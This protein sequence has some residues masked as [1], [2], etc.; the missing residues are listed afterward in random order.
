MDRRASDL[1]QLLESVIQ[2]IGLIHDELSRPA[3]DSKTG[4]AIPKAPLE[5][6]RRLKNTVDQFRL[7]LWAYVDSHEGEAGDPAA[8]LRHLRIERAAD[9]LGQLSSDFRHAG[10][11]NTEDAARL[12]EQIRTIEPMMPRTHPLRRSGTDH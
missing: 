2:Q 7:F 8:R 10:V 9:I 12:R 3:V 11:P 5:T 4:L 1:S 6:V